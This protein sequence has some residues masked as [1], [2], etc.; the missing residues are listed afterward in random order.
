MIPE[1]VNRFII[2]VVFICS[3]T[4]LSAQLV[5]HNDVL[6]RD[7][8]LNTDTSELP[9]A[10][11]S[12]KTEQTDIPVDPPFIKENFMVNTQGGEYGCNQDELR[13]A[14]DGRGY[15][16]F[17][18]L[19]YRNG[20]KQIYA[21]FYDP[22]LN[23]SGNNIIVN[24]STLTGNNSPFIA[25]NKKG[26]F[27]VVWLQNFNTVMAQR[28]SYTGEKRGTPLKV[29]TTWG[30]NTGNPSAAVNS[31][32]S[33]MVMWSSDGTENRF[34]IFSRLIDNSGVFLSDEIQVNDPANTVSSIGIGKY[35][36]VDGEGNYYL[37]WSS[38]GGTGSSKIFLQ[39]LNRSGTR[40]GG[41]TIV[42]LH[43]N[44]NSYFPE[45][46]TTS[47]GYS[48]IIWHFY[49]Q[50]V[51]GLNFSGRILRPD[52]TFSETEI[53][54]NSPDNYGSCTASAAGDSLFLI[55]MSRISNPL[56]Q[57]YTKTGEPTGDTASAAYGGPAK[58]YFS[59]NNI[60][61][62][63]NGLAA[64]VNATERMDR[65]VFLQRYTPELEAD[66]DLLKINDDSFSSIQKDP[67]IKFNDQGRSIVLWEDQKNG[68]K[69]L[70]ARV[71]DE[72]FNPVGEDIQLN[73][74]AGEE[75]F[76]GNKEV[77]ALSDGTFIILFSGSDDYSIRRIWLQAVNSRGE[78]SGSNRLVSQEN[79][80]YYKTGLNLNVNSKDEISVCWYYSYGAYLKIYNKHLNTVLN[81]K[82][83]IKPPVNSEFSN[84]KISVDTALTYFA[85]WK[86]Y[87][88]SNYNIPNKI[89]GAFYDKYGSKTS[90]VFLIDSTLTS[91][92][93]YCSHNGKDHVVIYNNGSSYA[94]IR[95]YEES[96]DSRYINYINFTGE[97]KIVRF[98]NG[99]LLFKYN[100]LRDVYTLFIN[101]AKRTTETYN[102]HHYDYLISDYDNYNWYNSADA[103]NDKLFFAYQSTMTEGTGA[104][105]WGN[106]RLLKNI[107]FGKEFFYPP[108]SSDF[109][110]NNYPNPFNNSTKIAYEV[111]AY[112]RVKLSVYDI[113]GRE[114]MVL[115]DKD[116]EKGIYE[117]ELN[118]S[119][120]PSG[121][122]FYRLESFDTVVKKMI[123]LK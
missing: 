56:F 61:E 123:L 27:V 15:S 85:V 16:A 48:L 14:A 103:Y 69:D 112:H 11:S 68:R 44:L 72:A 60:F 81:Q 24:E 41:N 120:I 110:H 105:I 23:K 9:N 1:A 63:R 57:Y 70:Y 51:P 55:L 109:L 118:A 37:T 119:G 46:N 19:D 94:V 98:E 78:K 12:L 66:G 18:W 17:V 28:F 79:N 53:N 20:L 116:H 43:D 117:V 99:K 31:D 38:S 10:N 4:D 50:S 122:Y 83:F 95:R 102:L 42:N 121:V 101:D 107:N 74:A 54:I 35:I 47:D 108:V 97:G 40:S 91:S 73:D 65:D 92:D 77:K 64:A 114:V 32:G 82:Q 8:I 29:N 6:Y 96:K 22:S 86:L 34:N 7:F 25:A 39:K 45:I 106:V 26:D 88:N 75:Y 13:G 5:R 59:I 89:Y 67:Y 104:D 80:S 71:Y 52:N 76:S 58:K 33:F 100:V 30:M 49:P 87:Q 93:I 90:D 2:A 84:L 115:V 111:L 3:F 62:Y 21:Q 36:S 113:L